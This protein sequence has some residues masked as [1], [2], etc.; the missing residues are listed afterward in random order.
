M[1]SC[2][3]QSMDEG[4]CYKCVAAKRAFVE[5]GFRRLLGCEAV[6][7][8]GRFW[9]RFVDT[10]VL[11]D[12]TAIVKDRILEI[13]LSNWPRSRSA[14][15]DDKTPFHS[16]EWNNPLLLSHQGH[17][18]SRRSSIGMSAIATVSTGK[19]P[20]TYSVGSKRLE[21]CKRVLASTLNCIWSD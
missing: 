19:R 7:N 15:L 2:R 11:A 5:D 10:R 9:F 6:A 21:Y 18:V 14:L 1:G 13:D 17:V 4:P 3:S 12:D 8:N 20:N 16:H